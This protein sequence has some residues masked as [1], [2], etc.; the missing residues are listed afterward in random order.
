MKRFHV[1]V[2]VDDLDANVRFYSTV[3]GAPPTVLKPDYAK[4]M[5][6]DPRVNFAIS[7]RGLK[8]GVDHLGVQVESET[9]L[10]S[11]RQQAAAA[12]IAALD[13]PKAECCYARA[14]KYWITDPQGVAW[15]TFHALDSIPVYGQTERAENGTAC[16][17]I[18]ATV[19]SQ[20]AKSGACCA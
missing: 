2:S 4:W 5:L 19:T 10:A 15:E 6:E 13:Q 17:G 20:S 16:C 14:D 8:A 3:F 9:E 1:H 18:P 7:K 12:E 11:L